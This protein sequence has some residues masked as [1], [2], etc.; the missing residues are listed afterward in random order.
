MLFF[1]FVFSCS[2]G[3]YAWRAIGLEFS[4]FTPLDFVMEKEVTDYMASGVGS[5]FFFGII[6]H[7]YNYRNLK[8]T[9]QQ[10]RIEKQQAE[11]DYLKS[12]TNPPTFYLTL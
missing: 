7:I 5:I 8:V 1:V 2:Y 11:L 3:L 12:Q 10:L 4:I 9:T 6:R